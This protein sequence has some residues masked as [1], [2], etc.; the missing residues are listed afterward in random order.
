VLLS[1]FLTQKVPVGNG[2]FSDS[3]LFGGSWQCWNCAFPT[4]TTSQLTFNQFDEAAAKIRRIL[5]YRRRILHALYIFF[6]I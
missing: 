3:R 5:G 6:D 1:P 4:T 2:V